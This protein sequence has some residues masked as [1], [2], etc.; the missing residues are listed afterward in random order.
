MT[1]IHW[2]IRDQKRCI[3]SKGSELVLPDGA[4]SPV[5]RSV[6]WLCRTSHTRM[7]APT[8][9]KRSTWFRQTPAERPTLCSDAPVSPLPP[10]VVGEGDILGPSPR[11]P[12]STAA[13]IIIIFV[14]QQQ[15]AIPPP[16]LPPRIGPPRREGKGP[17]LTQTDTPAIWM[18]MTKFPSRS[19]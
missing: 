2:K 5:S 4:C 8:P 19:F 9:A 10:T 17:P 16:L 3:F 14:Q 18:E 6:A 12:Q 13:I 1:I 15:H 11:I 7:T